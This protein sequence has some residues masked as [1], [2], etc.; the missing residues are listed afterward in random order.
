MQSLIC[1]IVLEPDSDD[2]LNGTRPLRVL[3]GSPLGTLL[4][5]GGS[6]VDGGC[7]D[8]S[9]GMQSG[10]ENTGSG[11]ASSCKELSCRT[12]GFSADFRMCFRFRTY[13]FPSDCT[14]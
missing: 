6:T 3:V 1:D 4:I 10:G 9:V 7:S 12:G 8:S 13:V 2:R 11:V 5:A 14:S